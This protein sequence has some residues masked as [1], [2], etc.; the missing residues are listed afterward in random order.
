LIGDPRGSTCAFGFDAICLGSV[1]ALVSDR[2]WAKV[3]GRTVLMNKTMEK[4]TLAERMR[5][6]GNEKAQND[7]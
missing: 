2:V 5:R 4:K 6:P 1:F 7:I 3:A